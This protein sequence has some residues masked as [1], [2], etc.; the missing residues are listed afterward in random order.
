VTCSRAV[1]YVLVLVEPLLRRVLWISALGNVL[2][3]VIT[4]AVL[5]AAVA[6]TVAVLS[7]VLSADHR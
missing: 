6:I 3:I 7:A 1:A 4:V 5:S 2:A